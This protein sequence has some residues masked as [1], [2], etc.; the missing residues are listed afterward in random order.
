MAS[1]HFHISELSPDAAFFDDDS[2]PE[3]LSH[4]E[5]RWPRRD[6]LSFLFFI[7]FTPH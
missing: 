2:Q 7:S 5:G 4:F 1:L 3:T 6:T